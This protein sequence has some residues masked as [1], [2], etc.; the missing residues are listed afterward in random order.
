[1]GNNEYLNKVE[2]YALAKIMGVD[3]KVFIKTVIDEGMN[4]GYMKELSKVA[5]EELSSRV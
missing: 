2:V 1:M 3:P 4:K 5:G